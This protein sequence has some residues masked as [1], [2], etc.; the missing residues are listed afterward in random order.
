M[1]VAAGI[2]LIFNAAAALAAGPAIAFALLDALAAGTGI[3][4]LAGLWTPIAGALA[5]VIATWN[6]VVDPSHIRSHILLAIIGA[7]LG[8]LGPGGWSIDAR[9]FGWKRVEIRDPKRD[10]VTPPL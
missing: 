6:A 4:L 2:G 1:R 3:L 7:A 9:L 10:D 8:L 5:A